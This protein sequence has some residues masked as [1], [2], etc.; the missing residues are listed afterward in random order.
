[1]MS[2]AL[3]LLSVTSLGLFYFSSRPPGIEGN[4]LARLFAYGTGPE[5]QSFLSGAELHSQLFPYTKLLLTAALVL[6]ALLSAFSFHSSRQT[7][8]E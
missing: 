5:I 1:M 7:E 3:A 4:A 8:S 2:G 6:M